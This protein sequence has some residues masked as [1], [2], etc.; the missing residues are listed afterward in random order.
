MNEV[1]LK[2]AEDGMSENF[3]PDGYQEGDDIFD[4]ESTWAVNRGKT[5]GSAAES[6]DENTSSVEEETA[7]DAATTDTESETGRSAEDDAQQESHDDGNQQE[8]KP[9]IL[10]LKVNHK[11]EDVNLDEMS[12]EDII[13]ALQ[14]AK[15][16][17]RQKTQDL[18]QKAYDKEL[19]DGMSP[20]IAQLAGK[21]AERGEYDFGDTESEDAQAEEQQTTTQSAPTTGG[22]DVMAEIKAIR[23]IMPNGDLPG[24]VIDAAAKGESPMV[25]FAK[26]QAAQSK[27]TADENK[28]FRQNAASAAKAP[29]KGVSGG[30]AT[31]DKIDPI[32][33]ALFKGFDSVGKW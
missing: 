1:E 29:V 14:K 16:F 22:R 26:W 27:K 24:T 10:K 28:V 19:G 18:Y 9:R 6:T 17:D 32:D 23:E 13:A 12:D 4:D 31:N 20:F 3:W 21:A 11:E 7:D 30:G 25:A 33:A 15:A 2:T 8:R 5:D